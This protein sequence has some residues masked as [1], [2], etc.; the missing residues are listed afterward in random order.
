VVFGCI[1]DP[2]ENGVTCFLLVLVWNKK[3]ALLGSLVGLRFSIFQGL[4]YSF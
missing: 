4:S 1:S 3:G 2:F